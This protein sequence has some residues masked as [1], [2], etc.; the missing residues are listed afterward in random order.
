MNIKI[1]E[2]YIQEVKELDS[3]KSGEQTIKLNRVNI[4]VMSVQYNDRNYYFSNIDDAM[5][6]MQSL[7]D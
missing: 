2:D 5:D 4:D 7:D 6:F 1:D 3:L